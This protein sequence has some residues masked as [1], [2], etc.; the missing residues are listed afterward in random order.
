M[1]RFSAKELD[2]F[3]KLASGGLTHKEKVE[4][5]K[6]VL[7]KL[8]EEEYNQLIAIAARLGLSQGGQYSKQ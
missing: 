2:A 8:S 4:A 5:K 6:L 1:K 3:M 7:E